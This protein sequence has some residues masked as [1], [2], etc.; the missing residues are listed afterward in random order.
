MAQST[1]LLIT[2]M[3]LTDE[4]L[5]RALDDLDPAAFHIRVLLTERSEP[6]PVLSRGSPPY[7][8]IVFPEDW[9]ARLSD[10]ADIMASRAASLREMLREM[11]FDGEVA[12]VLEEPSTLGEAVTRRA[13]F[14][15]L[16]VLDVLARQELL[17]E[18]LF[19]GA[20]GVVLNA[21]RLSA[22]LAPRHA[23]LAWDGSMPAL[24]A[25]HRALPILRRTERVTILRI[26]EAGISGASA[27][28]AVPDLRDWLTRHG[29]TVSVERREIEPEGV[30]ETLLGSC[31]DLDADLL[32]LGAFARSRARQFLLGGTTRSITRQDRLPV[33]LSH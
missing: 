24:R 7:G 1:V 17:S 22:A 2:D 8:P 27:D 23:A 32:V 19:H 11:G 30:A 33:L 14:C 29:C 28:A 12:S 13:A 10:E 9:I 4:A 16:A 26:E 25:I 20:V 15:D 5:R 18:M 6:L 3:N 21:P 31:R